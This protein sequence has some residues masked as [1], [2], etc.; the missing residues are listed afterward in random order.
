AQA[1]PA[2]HILEDELGPHTAKWDY[3]DGDGKLIACFYR[4]DT[5]DGKE[6][7]SWDVL[8]KNTAPPHKDRFLIN[9]VSRKISMWC[10]SKGKKLPKL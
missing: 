3:L 10:W 5:A 1:K 6:F 2:K 8:A 4:Y 9:P 7:R